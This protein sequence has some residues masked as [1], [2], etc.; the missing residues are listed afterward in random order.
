MW[1]QN[2][3]P[4]IPLEN[5]KLG[6][7]ELFDGDIGCN[8]WVKWRKIYVFR[9]MHNHKKFLESWEEPVWDIGLKLD[10]S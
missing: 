1:W 3:L 8:W 10:A 2:S 7:A 5:I 4:Q 6:R 9:Y